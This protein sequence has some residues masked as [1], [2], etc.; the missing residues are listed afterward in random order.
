VAGASRAAGG[1]NKSAGRGREQAVTAAP[2]QT[3]LALLTHTFHLGDRHAKT[4]QLHVLPGHFSAPVF[5][6]RCPASARSLGVLPWPTPSLPGSPYSPR[7]CR[8]SRRY[9]RVGSTPSVHRGLMAHRLLPPGANSARQRVSR[10]SR[11]EFSPHAWVFD[12]A[13]PPPLAYR[14]DRV[15]ASLQPDAVAALNVDFGA[16][17]QPTDTLSTLRA[18]LALHSHGRGQAVRYAFPCTTLSFGSPCRFIP[19]HPG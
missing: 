13:G 10:F 8:R 2:R 6:G 5:S 3:V 16:Q 11:M 4:F 12:S 15:V 9:Y 19:A 14:G 18:S 17:T 1:L 7:P